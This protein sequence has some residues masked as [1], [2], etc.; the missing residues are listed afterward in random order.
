MSSFMT[1]VHWLQVRSIIGMLAVFSL[2]AVT[3]Y[4]PGRRARVEQNGSIPFRD[5]E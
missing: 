1:I 5:D 4:W 3:T 2:I